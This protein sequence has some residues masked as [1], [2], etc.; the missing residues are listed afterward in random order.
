MRQAGHPW[1]EMN[2]PSVIQ[3]TRIT[4]VLVVLT[5]RRLNFCISTEILVEIFYRSGQVS[6]SSLFHSKKRV[7]SAGRL[8]ITTRTIVQSQ[9]AGVQ[10]HQLSVSERLLQ[11]PVL[12]WSEDEF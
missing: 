5:L 8:L 6:L 11:Y 2:G 10:E 9:K 12:Q 7:D 1:T 3:R 4:A